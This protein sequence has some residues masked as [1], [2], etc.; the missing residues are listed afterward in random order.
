[1]KKVHDKTDKSILSLVTHLQSQIQQ[2]CLE[3]SSQDNDGK[4]QVSLQSKNECQN[5][6]IAD[7]HAWEG[8]M[9]P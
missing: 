5:S 9:N 8:S 2:L 3:S 4:G 7:L 1:M 6:L